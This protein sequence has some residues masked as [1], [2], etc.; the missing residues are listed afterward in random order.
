MT[1]WRRL[2]SPTLCR[3][4]TKLAAHTSYRFF[5]RTGS[6]KN[7]TFGKNLSIHGKSDLKL[8]GNCPPR[9]HKV[10][11]IL[12]RKCWQFFSEMCIFRDIG[13]RNA[14]CRRN[15]GYTEA[16]SECGCSIVVMHWLPKPAMRVRFPSA[17]FSSPSAPD[18]RW[19]MN[20]G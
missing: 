18:P 1:A 3:N 13:A 19:K 2:T 8:T 17:A 14:C 11:R 6:A 12:R 9:A 7:G 20:I 4:A 5:G 15:V 10:R 16:F